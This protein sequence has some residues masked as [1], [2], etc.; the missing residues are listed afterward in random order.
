MD[1]CP[2]ELSNQQ[3]GHWGNNL[4]HV[5]GNG[6]DDLSSIDTLID[7]SP[8]DLLMKD[9]LDVLA[10]NAASLLTSAMQRSMVR[11]KKFNEAFAWLKEEHPAKMEACQMAQQEVQDQKEAQLAASI[12]SYARLAT[13]YVSFA[14]TTKPSASSGAADTPREE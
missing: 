14:G 5:T 6:A 13:A 8:K 7:D 9:T 4:M 2:R 11:K 10:D 1:G 3:E 12:E